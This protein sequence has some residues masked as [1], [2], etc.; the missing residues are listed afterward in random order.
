MSETYGYAY[1]DEHGNLQI[2]TVA[3]TQ[4]GAK[5]NAIVSVFLMW[6]SQSHSDDEIDQMFERHCPDGAEIAKV[7]VTN[8]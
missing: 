2:S 3:E 1:Q 8:S 5:V 4:R 7:T 6:V